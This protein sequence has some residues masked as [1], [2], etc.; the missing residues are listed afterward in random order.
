MQPLAFELQLLGAA[1]G[2]DVL[3]QWGWDVHTQQAILS[4][5]AGL[6]SATAE[7]HKRREQGRRAAAMRA[8]LAAP[9]GLRYA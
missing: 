9:Q 5:A 8:R 2:S 3:T 4:R 7:A 6:L 1:A